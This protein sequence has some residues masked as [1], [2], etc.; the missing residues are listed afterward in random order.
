MIASQASFRSFVIV[1]CCIRSPPCSRS[2]NTDVE[3]LADTECAPP[4]G[5]DGQAELLYTGIILPA[6]RAFHHGGSPSRGRQEGFTSLGGHPKTAID[7]R[8]K[9]AIRSRRSR[10]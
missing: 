5:V 6:P 8:L 10:C 3:F 4:L 7:G 9:P 2:V 1:R